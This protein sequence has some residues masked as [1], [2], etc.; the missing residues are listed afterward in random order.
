VDDKRQGADRDE[1]DQERSDEAHWKVAEEGTEGRDS[2][3]GEGSRESE[4]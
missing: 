2:D 3:D 4:S 1:R